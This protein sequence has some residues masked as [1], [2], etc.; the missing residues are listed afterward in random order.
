MPANGSYEACF[1][2]NTDKRYLRK[3][4]NSLQDPNVISSQHLD[5]NVRQKCS[6]H[7]K[8]I[9]KKKRAKIMNKYFK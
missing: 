3:D 8:M 2:D 9:H 7:P 5:D 4:I 1:D 6:P